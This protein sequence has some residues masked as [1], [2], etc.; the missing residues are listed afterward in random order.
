MLFAIIIDA[1]I[2]KNLIILSGAG[3]FSKLPLTV[4]VSGVR[5]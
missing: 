3:F 1:K 2:E 4:Y 5:D